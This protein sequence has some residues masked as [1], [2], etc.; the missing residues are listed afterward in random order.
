VPQP[1]Y[2][3]TTWDARRQCFTPQ[4]GVRRGP[5]TLW[6]LRR[7]LRRL[8][9]LGYACDRHDPAVLVTRRERA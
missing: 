8:R 5:Y 2:D 4:R 3:V 9:E 7:A 6:G 1:Y